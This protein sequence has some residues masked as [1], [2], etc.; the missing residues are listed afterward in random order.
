MEVIQPVVGVLAQTVV[1]KILE[2]N[3]KAPNA[4]FLIGGEVRFQV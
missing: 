4:V 1:D 2:Y 3:H